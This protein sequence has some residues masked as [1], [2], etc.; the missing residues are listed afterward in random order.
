MPQLVGWLLEPRFIGQVLI[1]RCSGDL[2][3][4]EMLALN[5]RGMVPI[6]VEGDIVMYESLA[7]MTFLETSGL[8]S[9]S[10]FPK[11]PRLKAKAL[12]R[13]HEANNAS[14]HVGEVVYYLRRTKPEDVNETYLGSKRD[15]MYS[16]IA[17]WERYLESG[18]E[19]LAGSEISVADVSFYPTLAYIVR[20][21]FNLRRFPRLFAY[22]TRMTKRE[23]IQK[24]W[25][26]HWKG[27][28]GSQPLKSI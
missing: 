28:T 13:M 9:K 25:P 23:T 5:P 4:P 26:P 14:A 22:Y 15:A 21:G 7:I 16:E 24:T 17:L 18:D 27:T 11:N 6:L 8:S 20:L 1:M 12:V 19:F 2:R 3:T 10:L